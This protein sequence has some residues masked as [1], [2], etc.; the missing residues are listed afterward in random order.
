MKIKD[1]LSS[2]RKYLLIPVVCLGILATIIPPA[3]V[4]YHKWLMHRT[5]ESI[6]S[7]SWFH[8]PFLNQLSLPTYFLII[9]PLFLLSI[10]IFCLLAI[11]DKA[12]LPEVMSGAN[13]INLTAVDLPKWQQIASTCLFIIAGIY[14]I[15]EVTA[16]IIWQSL[17]GIEVLG[18]ALMYLFAL[19]LKEVRLNRIKPFLMEHTGWVIAYLAIYS[20]V[21]II[22]QS[23]FGEEG[24]QFGAAVI[25]VFII[26]VIMVRWY[27]RIPMILWVSLGALILVAWGIDSWKYSVIGDEHDFYRSA[28]HILS[29]PVALVGKNFLTP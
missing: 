13:R 1:K 25:L 26:A 28:A 10:Y 2:Y 11:K 24:H 14:L 12:A 20:S 6:L 17:S 5:F 19:A 15:V 29:N 27:G 8:S 23:L 16:S 7:D 18:I 4:V 21:I 3:L 22:L 9:F